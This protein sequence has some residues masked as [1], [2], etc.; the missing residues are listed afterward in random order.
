MTETSI[1]KFAKGRLSLNSNI[2]KKEKIEEGDIFLVETKDG[3]I[4]YSKIKK[5]DLKKLR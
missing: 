4:I 3:K 2:V 5:E 1:E